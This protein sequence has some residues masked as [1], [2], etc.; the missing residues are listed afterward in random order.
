MIALCCA[1]LPSVLAAREKIPWSTDLDTASRQAAASDS[2]VLV[3]DV[4]HAT[5]GDKAAADANNAFLHSSLANP[6]QLA[7]IEH[8]F[9]PVL[10]HVGVPSCILYQDSEHSGVPPPTRAAQ[11]GRPVTYFCTANLQVLHFV[12][13]YVGAGQLVAATQWTIEN[14]RLTQEEAA[15]DATQWQTWMGTAHRDTLTE[16]THRTL[17]K[18][19]QRFRNSRSK[20]IPADSETVRAIVHAAT[21]V[22]GQQ[23]LEL[24]GANQQNEQDMS[25]VRLAAL[26]GQ[27]CDAGHLTLSM[28]PL[29]KLEVLEQHVYEILANGHCYTPSTPRIRALQ[30]HLQQCAARG[31][32]VLCVVHQ[33]P[34]KPGQLLPTSQHQRYLDHPAVKRRIN[35]F[36]MIPLMEIEL[37]ALIPLLGQQPIE[38]NS[39]E[40]L[41]FAVYDQRGKR[42]GV[43][44][45]DDV[46]PLLIRQLRTAES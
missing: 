42:A 16:S 3:V 1:L 5:P 11:Q 15:G 8:H 36:E 4:P 10:R 30:A 41:L 27:L 22:R 39:W 37:S 34:S 40:R 9:V 12:V 6:A 28:L 18:L 19:S 29:A 43:V 17:V 13:G 20:H 46:V 33:R 2:L 32:P 23:A 44:C 14:S 45:A 31:R 26:D 38:M 7:L 24:M 35:D 21:R 25:L